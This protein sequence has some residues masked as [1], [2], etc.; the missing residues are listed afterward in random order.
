VLLAIVGIKKGSVRLED[1]N[2]FVKESLDV[3]IEK[4]RLNVE[5]NVE[6]VIGEGESFRTA[7]EKRET[8]QRMVSLAEA[9]RVGRQI[10]RDEGLRLAIA[11]DI[12]S[13]PSVTT[14]Y[15]K[16][17]QSL[18]GNRA[19]NSVIKLNPVT[20]LLISGL[21]YRALFS[22][23]EVCVAII[24]EEKVFIGIKRGDPF[25]PPSLNSQLQSWREH[26]PQPK[27]T[28]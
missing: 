17:D 18:P 19:C 5:Y 1:T 14:T 4:R 25:K 26:P 15:L 7:T 10:K 28:F 11:Y 2:N 21:Q 13:A 12:G 16:A 22:G 8:V 9:N 3:A 20:V 24:H 23:I 27:Q 6:S